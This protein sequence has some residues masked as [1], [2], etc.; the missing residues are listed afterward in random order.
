M[1][2]PRLLGTAAL[3]AA[4]LAAVVLPGAL[5]APAQAGE[6]EPTPAQVSSGEAAM[7]ALEADAARRTANRD[8][9]QAAL[10]AAA[11]L[12]SARLE[13][14]T[15]AVRAQQQATLAEQAA[16]D[17]L[18]QA[19]HAAAAQRANL[20]TWARL[21]Y[22]HGTV[23]FSSDPVLDAVL[24]T[25]GQEIGTT[26]GVLRHLGQERSADLQALQVAQARQDHLTDTAV[27]AAQAASAAA[28][29]ATEAKDAADAALA[30]QRDLLGAADTQLSASRTRLAQARQ[31]QQLGTGAGP[32]AGGGNAVTGKVGSCRGGAVQ[33]YPNGTIPQAALCPLAADPRHYLRADAAYA[34]NR[35]N[36]AYTLQFGR[37]VCITDSY[38][39][40]QQQVRLYRTKPGLAAKPGT[41]NHGWGT[42]TDLCGGIQSYG[43]RQYRWMLLNAPLFGWFHPAWAR[44]G[45]GREEPWHWEFGG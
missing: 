34:F 39:T 44:Q 13:R 24:A 10:A 31:L 29:E 23:G 26:L 9:A 3:A 33:I 32:A 11:A 25:R 5:A 2:L 12:A 38:R 22:Q 1:P 21:T 16:Q 17:Q 28:I 6:R 45:A 42:A 30:E 41:S 20:G 37:P 18:E 8:D 7:A 15:I 43:T 27:G 4:V 35:L 36:R 14:Y 40:Y 19:V